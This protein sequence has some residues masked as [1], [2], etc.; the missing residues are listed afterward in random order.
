MWSQVY[1]EKKYNNNF[2]VYSK[3]MFLIFIL[4]LKL[5]FYSSL[6]NK[7]EIIL[8]SLRLSGI[9]NSLLGKLSWYRP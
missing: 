1:Y 6:L 5:I 9:V 2:W 3:F 8:K 7:R 4:F